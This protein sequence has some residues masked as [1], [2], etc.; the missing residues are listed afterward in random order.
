MKS[1]I[2]LL[3]FILLFVL[4]L[5]CGGKKE[6]AEKEALAPNL[7]ETEPNDS[8]NQALVVTDGTIAKGFIGAK[9]DQDWYKISIPLDSS[10]ILKS[11]LTGV[12]G[13][14][15]KM[16]LFD[17]EGGEILDVNKHKE[18]EGEIIPNQGLTSGD[19]FLRVR[20]LWAE[21]KERKFNDT[22]A[23]HLHI[24]LASIRS[25]VE[26]ESNNKAVKSNLIQANQTIQGY[27]SPYN[28]VDWY[29][30][31]PPKQGNHYLEINL[32][33][34]ADVDLRLTVYDPIEALLLSRNSGGKG[35]GESILNLGIDPDLEYYYLVVQ[36]GKWQTNEDST[37][38]LTTV[39]KPF[40]GKME[41]EPND[42]LVR[43]S[44]IAK[45]D[46]TKGFFDTE[47][48]VDWYQLQCV[49]TYP[50]VARIEAF[51]IPKVDLKLTLFNGE[52]QQ[53]WSVNETG[54][55]EN[56]I[57][58]NFGIKPNTD[59][60][61]KVE[62]VAKST[63]LNEEYSL[64]VDIARFLDDGEFESNN[65]VESATDIRLNINLKGFIHPK[66]DID[67]Y[68]LDLSD[69][70]VTGLK[71]ILAGIVKVNTDMVLYDAAMQEIA[72]ANTKQTEETETLSVQIGRGVYF[73]KVYDNDGKESNYRDKYEI[74]ALLEP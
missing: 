17:S 43:A 37:Y 53:V 12:L 40:E 45:S 23:Y 35:E 69:T 30:I 50:Q 8:K 25:D 24:H 51:G 18:D 28:D 29:K 6:I 3:S 2:S 19:Y 38:Q 52:E 44:Q 7:E 13:L 65:Q 60:F 14:N 26:F 31:I 21:G 41:A 46:T 33:D 74:L 67:Y 48:D 39:F 10:A 64:F 58:T 66:G 9:K 57:I 63:N 47:N 55:M 22:T 42:R 71:L 32:S 5:S 20:E 4:C 34:L 72:E 15:L 11:E 36:G 62:N 68:K 54:K 1:G 49:E 16:E 73:I 61:L 70:H 56:E 27:I 59:Y